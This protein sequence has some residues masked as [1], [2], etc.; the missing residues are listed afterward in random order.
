MMRDVMSVI[1]KRLSF[2]QQ[3]KCLSF[4]ESATTRVVWSS[5]FRGLSAG[6][7]F[8]LRTFEFLERV[9]ERRLFM[10]LCWG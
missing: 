3:R 4:D 1:R 5:L 8:V 6:S 2:D 7:V 9:L 10:E